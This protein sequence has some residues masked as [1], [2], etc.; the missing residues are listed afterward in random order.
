MKN[1]YLRFFYS[2]FLLTSLKCFTQS[3][4]I[5]NI[6]STDTE[7]VRYASVTFIDNNDSKRKYSTLTDTSGNYQLNIITKVEENKPIYTSGFE[8]E[9]NY[10]NPFS[11]STAISYKLNKQSFVSIKIFDILG[12]QVKSFF[13][14]SEVHGVHGI[15]WDGKNTIGEKV[16]PGIY[17][18]RLWASPP[19]GRASMASPKE[20][21]FNQVRKFIFIK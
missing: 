19:E 11:T 18:Y 20:D 10:P 1:K 8:L 6:V 13:A 21:P 7:P 15:V 16:T 9:Q 4:L 17:F 14:N 12:S 2:L 3:Y 5:K